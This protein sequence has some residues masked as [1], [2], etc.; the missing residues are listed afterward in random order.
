MHPFMAGKL[1]LHTEVHLTNTARERRFTSVYS[2]M[3]GQGT[4]T[5]EAFLTN[6]AGVG[7]LPTV[8][9]LVSG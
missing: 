3:V 2:R 5:S 6:I 9:S 7:L 1:T 8:R 4:L